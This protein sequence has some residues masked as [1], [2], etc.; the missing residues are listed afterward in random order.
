MLVKT[1]CGGF[2]VGRERYFKALGAVEIESTFFNPPKAAT[3]QKWKAEAPAGFEFSLRASSLITH[4]CGNI[5]FDKISQKI[6]EK[7]KPF[8]GHFKET[9]EVES[10]WEAT[11]NT[12]LA[13]GARFVVFE[14]PESFY[15]DSN[16]L[17]DLYRF[18]KEIRRENLACVWQ[19]SKGWEEKMVA[20]VC[21]DLQLIHAVDP[22]TG[23]SQRGAVRYFRLRGPKA[24]S[25]GDAELQEI[26]AQC[27]EKTSYVFFRHRAAWFDARRFAALGNG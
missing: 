27:R 3:A 8:C 7:R 6:G 19:P 1:G 24:G 14:S 18:F 9:L 11:R 13:L 2:P 16:H 4:S 21:G 10:A 25:Y 12:A 20:K 15:P 22:L 23:V 5:R 26:S 17:K